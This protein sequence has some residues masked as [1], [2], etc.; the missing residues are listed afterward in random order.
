[1]FFISSNATNY[2]FSSSTGNDYNDGKSAVTAWKSINKINAVNL[3]PGDSV[4]LMCNDTFPGGI[5]VSKSGNSSNPIYYG[6]Y[7]PG[8]KPIIS[9]KTR[10]SNWTETSANIWVASCPDCKSSV[11]NFFIN[12]I[13]QPIGRWPN[14][15]DANKG[16][17]TYTSHS[18][19]TQITDPTLSNDINWTGAEVVVRN[20]RWLLNKYIILS[21]N[22][23]TL[24]LSNGY[25]DFND[26][27]GYFIQ[28]DPRTLDQQGE[29]YFNPSTKQF[30]LYSTT[31][32]NTTV[33][34]ATKLDNLLTLNSGVKYI[35]IEKLHFYGAG[36]LAIYLNNCKNIVLR[37]NEITGSGIDG[38]TAKGS[39]Y[40]TFENNLINMTNNNA[41][42]MHYSKH[43]TIR[44]NIIKNTSLVA[45]MGASL[46]AQYLAANI[47][48]GKDYLIEYNIIDSVGYIG[49]LFSGDS[50]LIKNNVISNFCMVKDDGGGLYTYAGDGSITYS[51]KLIGNII[52]NGIGALEG[53]GWPGPNAEGIYLDDKTNH[54]EILDNTVFNCSDRGI[55]LGNGNHI[56]IK[57]NNIYNNGSQICLQHKSDSP[58]HPVTNCEVD[59]NNFVS[60]F[61]NQNIADYITS[62]NGISNFGT[63]D[64]NYYCRPVGHDPELW[65]EY[66]ADGV[67][68]DEYHTPE[69]WSLKY[70]YD[71]H[72]GKSPISVDA[73]SVNSINSTTYITNGSFDRNIDDWSS[74]SWGNNNKISFVAGK[75]VSGGVL[76]AGFTSL[77]GS[78]EGNLIVISNSFAVSPDKTYRLKFDAKSNK[79]GT[80]L[81]I[82]PF[83]RPVAYPYYF[84]NK[85]SYSLD[86][87]YKQFEYI[88][89]PLFAKPNAEFQFQ[90]SEYQ[91]DLW[92]DNVELVEVD[93]TNTNPDDYI[94][95]EFNTTRNDKIISLTDTMVDVKGIPVFGD[96]TLK[97]FSSIIL[98]KSINDSKKPDRPDSIKGNLTVCQGSQVKYS[99]APVPGATYYTWTLPD[100]WTG[101]STSNSIIAKAGTGGVI[102]VIANNVFGP[103]APQTISVTS[104]PIPDTPVITLD[105]GTLQSDT[106]EGNQWYLSNKPI[107]NAIKDSYIPVT[108]GNYYVVVS[109]KGCP[110]K[111][112]NTISFSS[113]GIDG[114]DNNK[115]ISV[116]P[117]PSSGKIKVKVNEIFNSDYVAE[118]YDNI[119]T[120]IQRK[121]NNKI[122]AFFDLDLS[123]YSK[124]FYILH[125]YAS[126][127]SFQTKIIKR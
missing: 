90:I 47:Q 33:T 54:V 13:P 27:F 99:I 30:S 19:S 9:G 1:M 103:S 109:L 15:T 86:T 14:V 108:K 42:T 38:V 26:N 122:E 59:S 49:V 6:N 115:G 112:S 32:P 125:I 21:Q 79:Q 37:N 68:Y 28:N 93:T 114:H 8:N 51:K 107:E 56:T 50:I 123:K 102:S 95:F 110:S 11:T 44:N 78:T 94:R 69:S 63:F 121:E 72:S 53:S 83:F 97:P 104:N 111:S 91:G 84:S 57:R 71:I 89:K 113:A 87:A 25:P 36:Q 74:F 81:K 124:G 4:L 31:N 105:N 76:H 118:V 3:L 34:E 62:D 82:I 17:R 117:N 67:Q 126:D 48:Y 116:Y 80:T 77:S 22:N 12:D 20:Y 39:E 127:K 16:Y 88:F 101:T 60:K 66:I 120:L 45:G 61:S 92:L 65:V 10:V 58:N 29:W 73:Y 5:I 40:I 55:T 100:G 119:G 106:K 46:D 70:N 35:S 98:F 96:I 2:Y 52:Y 24:K 64:Y 18:G 43:L 23:G 85:K 75:G 41:L 7:G